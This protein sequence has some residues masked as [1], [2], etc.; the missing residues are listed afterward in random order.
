MAKGKMSGIFKQ[1]AKMQENLEKA[2]K[3]LAL[4]TVEATSG[5]GMVTVTANGRQQI[6][7]IKIDPEVINSDDP[8]MLEDLIVAAVNQAIEKS[9]EMATEHMSKLAGGLLSNL[10]GNMK[11]PGFMT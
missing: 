10:P 8:E 4:M 1:A 6:L 11:F 3:E 2:Q 7:S 5:G 9:N